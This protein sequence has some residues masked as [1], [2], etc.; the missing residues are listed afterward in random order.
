MRVSVI[1]PTRHRQ[2]FLPGLVEAFR[3][4]D[5]EDKELV[6]LDDSPIPSTLMAE[7][8]ADDPRISYRFS[9]QRLSIGTK[10]NQLIEACTGEHI[11]QFDDDDYYAPHYLRYMSD[12]L[13]RVDFYKLDGWYLLRPDSLFFGYWDTATA[14]PAHY[15]VGPGEPPRLTAEAFLQEPSFLDN[16][17][18]F[19]F[20][21]AFRRD[22]AVEIRFDDR[23]WGEDY[24]FFVRLRDA[25]FSVDSGPDTSGL[26]LHI[27]H[28]DN[29]SRTFPQYR[30]PMHHLGPTF[31]T[32]LGE[33]F[34]GLRHL[35]SESYREPIT[36]HESFGP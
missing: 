26:V 7:I 1:T 8:A 23:D 15:V 33:A 28:G 16:A 12:Q 17:W 11:V 21:Y 31:G 18:G 36:Q 9:P 35:L 25:G 27:I 24:E 20:S 4:Q 19:G 10:R 13:G 14:L 34:R 29:T 22:A 6:I 3:A 5:H 30:L 32:G 2:H